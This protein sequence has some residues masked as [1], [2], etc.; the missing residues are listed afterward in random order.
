MYEE[1]WKGTLNNINQ[2]KK[3]KQ[4]KNA[5]MCILYQNVTQRKFVGY[6]I[7]YVNT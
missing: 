4:I 3:L 5:K 6:L 2:R 7:R 1:Y